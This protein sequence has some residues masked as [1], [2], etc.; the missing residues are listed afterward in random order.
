[1]AETRTVAVGTFPI[2]STG[3]EMRREPPSYLAHAA[4]A[5]VAAKAAAAREAYE[6]GVSGSRFPAMPFNASRWVTHQDVAAKRTRVGHSSTDMQPQV[7]PTNNGGCPMMQPPAG[8]FANNAAG[9]MGPIP[10]VR[11][12]PV[13]TVRNLLLLCFPFTSTSIY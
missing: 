11:L 13:P 12:D 8:V 3:R 4:A 7:G 1:M 10:P 2:A 6:R 9:P 5:A